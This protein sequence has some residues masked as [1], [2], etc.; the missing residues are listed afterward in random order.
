MCL[1]IGQHKRRRLTVGMVA[2]L[3][4]EGAPPLSFGPDRDSVCASK[5]SPLCHSPS[6]GLNMACAD[7]CRVTVLYISYVV[8]AQ[9]FFTVFPNNNVQ[10]GFAVE[11]MCVVV[12][13]GVCKKD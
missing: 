12:V 1:L 10:A 3:F 7:T 2:K 6:E 11:R 8:D 5:C 13:V 9:L 4:Q